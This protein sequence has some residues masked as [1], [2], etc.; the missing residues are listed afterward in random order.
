[1]AIGYPMTKIDLDN[2]MG[3]H[4]QTLRA[5]LLAP[6]TFKNNFFDDATL[7]TDAF[8]AALGYTGSVS[9]LE[10]QQIRAAYADMK[11]LSDIANGTATQSATN[12]FWFNA[13]HLLGY[14]V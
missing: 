6:V 7:G 14:N 10:I 11:K 8:L 13:K 1:M 12:D 9:S 5:A 3:G 4:V 2:R